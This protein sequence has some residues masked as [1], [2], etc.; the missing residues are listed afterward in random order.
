MSVLQ[1]SLDLLKRHEGFKQFPYT[2]TVGKLTVGY[3]RNLGGRGIDNAEAEYLLRNDIIYT[4]SRLSELDFWDSLDETRQ[5]VLV[6]MAVNLG[7]NGLLNFKKTLLAIRHGNY[8]EAS[9]EMLRSKWAT[10]VGGRAVELSNLM[11]G[12]V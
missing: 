10:Q 5:A 12:P 2:D 8:I 7:V 3:G 1:I 4:L 6:D 11:R 9:Y